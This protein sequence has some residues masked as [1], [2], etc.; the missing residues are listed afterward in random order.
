MAFINL[1]KA[2]AFKN[3]VEAGSRRP[4]YSN[5]KVQLTR[6]HL[7]AWKSAIDSALENPEHTFQ[8]TM[9]IWEHEE[10]N[11]SVSLEQRTDGVGGGN[12]FVQPAQPGPLKGGTD[13]FDSI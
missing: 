13:D 3:E 8:P 2:T 12:G 10:G 1:M 4:K 5:S 7:L 9:G 6:E 11:L